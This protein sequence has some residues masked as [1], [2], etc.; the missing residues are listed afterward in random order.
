MHFDL[1]LEI[2]VDDCWT[3]EDVKMALTEWAQDHDL[4]LEGTVVQKQNGKNEDI[5]YFVV[6]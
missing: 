5:E 3:V 4:E 1:K 6:V 2:A